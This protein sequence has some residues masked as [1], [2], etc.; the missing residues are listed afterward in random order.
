[1]NIPPE[2]TLIKVFDFVTQDTQV[3]AVV[4]DGP[5]ETNHGAY[6]R[7]SAEMNYAGNN[8]WTSFT[9]CT[10]MVNDM[11]FLQSEIIRG[12]MD[13]IKKTDNMRKIP[14]TPFM[15]GGK[16]VADNIQRDNNGYPLDQ[17]GKIDLASTAREVTT[18]ETKLL[19]K[20]QTN[21]TPPKKK[22]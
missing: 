8:Y 2:Y 17:D 12:L 3:F 1:M 22:R 13:A 15:Q 18:Y 6:Y 11:P 10:E 9:L 14:P 19:S 16:V 5:R 21:K 7:C 4:Y 20:K